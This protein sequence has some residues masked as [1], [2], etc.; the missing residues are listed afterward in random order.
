MTSIA[1]TATIAAGFLVATMQQVVTEA[2]AQVARIEI[3]ALR[4]TTL[5]DQQFLNGV[6]EGQPATIAAELRLP[7]RTADRI[8]AIVL[9]HG[10]GG[11]SGSHERWAQ[12]FIGMGIAVLLVDS[13]TGRGIVSTSA[14]QEALGRLAMI[15]DAYR[16]LDLLAPD[17]RID[18]DRIALIGFSRGGQ[19]ALYAS[20]RRF[21]KMHGRP[22]LEFAA[23]IPF[24]PSCNTQF[25][26]DENVT[27]RPVRIHHGLTDNYVPIGPC[28]AYVGRLHAAGKRNVS[29]TEYPD[30]HHAFDNPG[31]PAAVRAERS[32]STALCAMSE[33]ESGRIINTGTG[34]PFGYRDTCVRLGPTLGYHPEAHAAAVKAVKDELAA[35]FRLR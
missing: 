21:Q 22:G 4:T 18:S 12:E 29:L 33:D 13:F 14:N 7:R 1:R 10:S 34:K 28:K 8:P 30:A 19:A 31:N 25:R 20:L 2:Q 6:K 9:L 5:T 3:L 16:A 27:T 15:I 17:T 35:V 11:L 24:Y 26:D 23:Y 32:Q